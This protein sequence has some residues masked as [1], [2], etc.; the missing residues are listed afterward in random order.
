MQGFFYERH[1]QRFISLTKSIIYTWK[2]SRFVANYT[3]K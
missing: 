3:Y 2:N 1:A